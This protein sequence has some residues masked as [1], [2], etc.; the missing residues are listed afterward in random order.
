MEKTPIPAWL[1][2]PPIQLDRQPVIKR[3][4]GLPFEQL[5]WPDF[6]RLILRVVAADREVLDCRVYGV[7][8]QKQHGIDLL[9]AR[10][11][12]PDEQTCFQCKKV[13]AFRVSDVHAAIKRFEEGPWATRVREFTLCVACSLEDTKLTDA[14]SEE[15]MRLATRGIT[16]NIWD[17]ALS[18]EL[19]VRLKDFPEIVDDFF[20][21]EWVRTF[22]GQEVA[23]R[24][25]ERLDGC[26]FAALRERLSGL[27][28]V[29]FSQHDPGL[30]H[31]RAEPS[32]YLHL[33]V[34]ADIVESEALEHSSVLGTWRREGTE[35]TG[36]LTTNRV[37]EAPQTTS[38]ASVSK[39]SVRRS[40][41]EWL[42]DKDN[43]V[44]LG[45]PGQGKSA[46]LRQL[47]LVLN[48]KDFVM[49][50]PLNTD[51][52]RR[53]PVW[54]SFAR[55]AAAIA[56]Q[57]T[58]SVED[59]FC[60][61]LHQYG[62]KDI[63][64]LFRRAL[65]SSEFLLLVDG[66]DEAAETSECRE[67]LD[68]V[69][70]FGKSH[71]AI[72]ICTSR[73]R[74]FSSLP[75][76]PS[77]P[78]VTLAPLNDNQIEELATRWFAIAEGASSGES[79]EARWGHAK[80]RGE[81]FCNAIKA[82][83]RTH[84]LARNPL[85]CQALI[86]LF[87]LSH[88]LPE[89][90]I[91]AYEEIIDL[92][93]RRHPQAREHAGYAK[94]PDA[95]EDLR[96]ADLQ[97]ILI[98]IAFDTQSVTASGIA[99]R[100]R[101]VELCAEYLEDDQI[102]LGILRPK[103]KRRASEI[104]ELFVN[105]FGILIE[106]SP[107]ELSFVHLSLQEFLAAKA[108][109]S[110]AESE[111]L[112]WVRTVALQEHWREC[113]T[114]WFGIQGEIG[115]RTLAARGSQ[116]LAEIGRSG[117]WERLQTLS[118][119]TELS[120]ADLGLPVGEARIVLTE[121]IQ[122]VDASPFPDLRS[123]LARSIAI[124]ALGSSIKEECAAAII[125]W[126]PAPIYFERAGLLRALGD[127]SASVD[128]DETLRR[129]LLDERCECRRA[130]AESYAKAFATN[131][132][133]HSYLL[134]VAKSNVLPEV[135]AAALH[136]LAQVSAWTDVALEAAEWNIGSHAPELRL[137]CIA[138]RVRS[139]R[140]TRNDLTRLLTILSTD[141]LDYALREQLNRLICYGWPRDTALRSRCLRLSRQEQGTADLPFPLEYLLSSYQMDDEI[142]SAIAGLLGR[143]GMHMLLD[144]DRFWELLRTGYAGHQIVVQATR[145]AIA[146]YKKQFSAIM[147]HPRTVPAYLVLSDDQARD[148]L[149]TGYRDADAHGRYWIASTLLQGWLKD[150]VVQE[151]INCWAN[152]SVA[153]AAPL[154]KYAKEIK[155]IE[156]ERLGWLERLVSEAENRIVSRPIYALLKERPDEC[157]YAL[158]SERL[159][160]PGIWY[161]DRINIESSLAAAYPEREE[162]RHTVERAFTESDGP[163]LSVLAAAYQNDSAIR[164]RLLTAAA[165]ASVD[166]RLSIAS[167]LMERG[168]SLD[169]IERLTPDVLKEETGKVRA[170]ALIARA[171]A[172]RHRPSGSTSFIELLSIEAVAKGVK[173]DLRRRTAVAALLEMGEADRVAQL[174]AGEKL[175]Q[176]FGWVDLDESDPVSLGSFLDHWPELQAAAAARSVK[177]E[178]PVA[179][180]LE[181]GYGSFLERAST[182]RNQLYESL[183][184]EN[185]EWHNRQYLEILSRLY[186][187]SAA[188]RSTLCKIL[189][190]QALS[191]SSG[192]HACLAARLLGEIF[193]GN[194][195]VLA[196][197]VSSGQPFNLGADSPGVLGHLVR[198]WPLSDLASAARGSDPE[199]RKRWSALDRLI[200]ATT[201]G[202]WDEA[203]IAAREII[204]ERYR[205]GYVEP[206]NAEALR[207][208]ARSDEALQT[209]NIWKES[210]DGNEATAAL[211]LLGA[212][213]SI[214]RED[215]D[216]IK[217][218]FNQ[219]IADKTKAPMDGFEPAAGRVIPWSQKAYELL[220][221]SG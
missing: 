10:A 168:G 63:Q 159:K 104:I 112:L 3:E 122:D 58:I 140:H 220:S 43:C 119:R 157:T 116:M 62:Y 35:S 47:A 215:I 144:S 97:D 197:V 218:A 182:V 48:T 83:A 90:R 154:A 120:T 59:F 74:Q 81:G 217:S 162:S 87:R 146:K 107:G 124:G 147:W 121:A 72:V 27:Y 191:R 205:H 183:V 37:K 60:D 207:I 161:Y 134:S 148:E 95:L 80:P 56:R 210:S 89:A 61:W 17:G 30:R 202:H 117:E 20:G 21:R 118:L 115:R 38:T 109:T 171:R 142:A 16:L 184:A 57:P 211:M 11:A 100:D 196:N 149:I 33:Y 19:N 50:M 169:L 174:F 201:W 84:E 137:A 45:E 135:R 70:T 214:H 203:S 53:L 152:E 67:A 165:P 212:R 52:L 41:W 23:D 176:P 151:Q 42:R 164:P 187:R 66:L 28:R 1:H 141:S 200:C 126:M 98:K 156:R 93:L 110:K 199:D 206:E 198:A 22:N 219:S 145:S 14:M 167:V 179:E 129:A 172:C 188:L 39:Y 49:E 65:R 113:L 88:R 26:D 13:K 136:A 54:I 4:L 77:W 86:E 138:T 18:G 221:R 139:Q 170:A 195:E 34:P 216:W 9:A 105:H 6:E 91:R 85:L 178:L 7:P 180:L 130:A 73:P 102:G 79:D 69:V 12:S 193:G 24:L 114:S 163:P 55:L 194:V 150:A 36:V 5:T 25:L 131:P 173:M 190:G 181:A 125:R 158:I 153:L 8:G 132:T 192:Q 204:A 40:A 186:P 68:R 15:R 44:V 78:S 64:P 177:I 189:G 92:F 32:D 175:D 111:Q 123:K 108:V 82:S 96:D 208:W 94:R 31:W 155:P 101:C 127:W 76:P 143:Y 103:S 185:K 2:A 99:L 51:H 160:A 166:V 46:L 209:L 106:R 29:I 213:P 71:R 75:V 128:L 133:A